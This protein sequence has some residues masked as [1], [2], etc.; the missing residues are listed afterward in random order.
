[1]PAEKMTLLEAL[2]LSALGFEI[3]LNDG[4]I[5]EVKEREE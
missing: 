2:E 1:M 5:S 3:N 4:K